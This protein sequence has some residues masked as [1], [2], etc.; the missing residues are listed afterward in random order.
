MTD[1]YITRPLVDS[2]GNPAGSEII[3]TF[4]EGPAPAQTLGARIAEL[5]ANT[6]FIHEWQPIER[7]PVPKTANIG[8][9]KVDQIINIEPDELAR[10]LSK[11]GLPAPDASAIS[12]L[13][14]WFKSFVTPDL[15]A[16]QF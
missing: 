14:G 4:T 8:T 9:A 10:V 12:K 6:G 13:S 7:V 5:Q 16:G 15:A 3:E 1:F 11:E 2:D